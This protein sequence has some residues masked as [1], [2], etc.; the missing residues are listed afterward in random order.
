MKGAGGYRIT[1]LD[2]VLT[3][4][5]TILIRKMTIKICISSHRPLKLDFGQKL[6]T[7]PKEQAFFHL[8]LST[9]QT[10]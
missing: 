4:L 3:L 1:S 10:K 5:K 8:D 2:I 9:P 7:M 6:W